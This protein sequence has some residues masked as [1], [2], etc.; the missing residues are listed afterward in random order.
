MLQIQPIFV[1]KLAGSHR[2]GYCQ[3]PDLRRD[4][5]IHKQ[6]RHRCVPLL[7]APYKKTLSGVSSLW[8]YT[9]TL[10]KGNILSSGQR[11]ISMYHAE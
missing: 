3:G 10:Q 11:L 5:C 4:D 2:V 1:S 9:I 6:K 8:V 7:L